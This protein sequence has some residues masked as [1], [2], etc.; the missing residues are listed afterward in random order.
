MILKTVN[1][2][3]NEGQR[4]NS[5]LAT[6]IVAWI[7]AQ[8]LK[9][10]YGLFKYGKQDKSRILWRIIWAG[11]L[12]SAHSAVI[13]STVVTIFNASGI[14]S[15][16]FGLSLILSFIV[17]YDRLRMYSIYNA[18]QKKYPGF[19]KEIQA[20]P[21]LKDLVGHRILEITIGVFIGA[22][23]GTIMAIL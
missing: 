17:I 9:V 20:D 6:A 15:P 7:F 13:T 8:F 4:M 3:F 21:L 11:G 14:E 12:P 2:I 1:T 19:A 22:G 18:F 23:V 16:V 5:I 10:A